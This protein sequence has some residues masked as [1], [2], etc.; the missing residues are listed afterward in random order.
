MEAAGLAGGFWWV[1]ARAGGAR[2]FWLGAG[3]FWLAGQEFYSGRTKPPLHNKTMDSKNAGAV[4]KT[5]QDMNAREGRS[6]CDA[7]LKGQE[8]EHGQVQPGAEGRCEMA[9]QEGDQDSPH[10]PEKKRRAQ[11]SVA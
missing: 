1:L 4:E 6:E 10:S 9:R 7:V 5:G 8:L 2:V 11:L 3:Y